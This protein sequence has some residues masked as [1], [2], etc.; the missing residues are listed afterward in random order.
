MKFRLLSTLFLLPC[1]PA[2]FA[3]DGRIPIAS[4]PYTISAPGNYYL[5]KDLAPAAG[6][7]IT[8]NADNVVLDLNRHLITVVTGTIG[9]FSG[10]H[11]ELTLLNGRLAGGAYSVC[12]E[13]TAASPVN[14]HYRV[15]GLEVTGASAYGI[16]LSGTPGNHIRAELTGNRVAKTAGVGIFAQYL[17]HSHIE[18]NLS[19]E[20]TIGS[21]G[22]GSCI[23]FL[24]IVD[25]VLTGNHAGQ[26][27]TDGLSLF[28]GINNRLENNHVA[29]AGGVGLRV[30]NTANGN[31]ILNN[32]VSA[33]ASGIGVTGNGNLVDGNTV[34][35]STGQAINVGGNNNA[36]AN[37]HTMNN[38]TNGVTASG[39]GNFIGGGNY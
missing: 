22:G 37:N 2:L 39:T 20:A 24:I 34:T 11:T 36:Y 6:T 38:G 10:N 15:D 26:C 32:S 12:F 9:I 31:S 3:A 21:S 14:P 13:M 23:S 19:R 27:Q 29:S 30:Y 5:T 33:S 28:Q 4:A 7:A 18:N 35:T 8:I 1:G 16:Y 25:S 17:D